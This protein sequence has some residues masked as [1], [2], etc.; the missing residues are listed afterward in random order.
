[1]FL[2]HTYR[3]V[4]AVALVGLVA[5]ATSFNAASARAEKYALLVGVRQYSGRG[6]KPLTYTEADMVDL[7][8]AL[9][10]CGFR[11][12]N[13]VLMTQTVGAQKGERFQPESARIRRELQLLLQNRTAADTV[14]VGFSGHG[15]QLQST[16]EFY[17]C[18]ADSN[19]RNKRTM[20][21]LGEVYQQLEHCPA[22]FKLLMADACRNDPF[23]ESQTRGVN[24]V[25][26]VTRPQARPVPGGV[27]A[28]FACSKGQEAY[29]DNII[30]NGVF[31]HFVVKALRGAAAKP[32]TKEV[33]LTGLQEYVVRQV[34]EYVRK[35]H[36]HDQVPE[37][38]NRTRGLVSLVGGAA[39]EARQQ[40]LAL[41]TQGKGLSRKGDVDKALASFTQAV[42]LDGNNADAHACR[43]DA[44][45]DK[46]KYD[47]ALTECQ[48]A[49]QLDPRLAVAYEYQADA[50]IGKRDYERAARACAQALEIDPRLAGAYNDRGVL[51]ALQGRPQK[52]ITELTRALELDPRDFRAFGNRG[53]AYL[54][55]GEY[56]KAVSDFSEALRTGP[57]DGSTYYYRAVAHEKLGHADLAKSDRLVAG[58]LGFQTTKQ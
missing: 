8:K 50:F 15:L 57:R 27:A 19:V 54:A 41:L 13:I 23:E 39:D 20:V 29:E 17:F 43:A 56:A 30:K 52:A 55:V 12:E 36:H 7:A 32:G 24:D 4:R 31:F 40:L 16:N 42:K 3:L 10:L 1:M 26:S 58:Q 44:L 28:F 53:S 25:D 46:G 34:T 22:G 47:E 49:L 38:I 6:L 51:H 5:L 35:N 37:M 21:S 48:R 18:P 11:P 45:N 33:T 9:Q 2:T 14:F